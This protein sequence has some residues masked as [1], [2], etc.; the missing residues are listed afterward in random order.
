MNWKCFALLALG[1]FATGCSKGYRVRLANYYY[2]PFDSVIVG[3][4]A[5]IYTGLE[6]EQ[7]SD[8]Q[9]IT[10]GKHSVLF[11]T[12][13]GERFF[14]VAPLEKG[15]SGDYTI[16]IDGLRDVRVLRD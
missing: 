7:V 6:P 8:Y 1:C 15:G 14:G 13:R 5:V 11:V 12:R 10:S 9:P 16:Q 2:E 4:R 3:H